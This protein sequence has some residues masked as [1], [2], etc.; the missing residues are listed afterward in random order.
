MTTTLAAP[1]EI[2]REFT[3]RSRSQLQ[4]AVRRFRRN[5]LAMGGLVTFLLM[6]LAAFAGPHFFSYRFDAQS[7]TL[8]AP[9]GTDGHLFGTDT[10]GRDVLLLTLRGIQWSMLMAAVFV[11]VACLLG[12]LVGAVSGYFGGLVDDVLMRAVDITLTLPFLAVVIVV[13]AAYPSARSPIGVAVLIALFSWMALARIVRA[14]FLSLRER[15]YVEAAQALGASDRRIVIRHL[16]PNSLGQIIVWATLGA[17]GAIGAEAALSFLGYGVQGSDI[18]LGRLVAEGAA[19]A[20]SRPWL[21]YF[22][23]LTLLL[24]VLAVSLV[25]D[26]IQDAFDPSAT[27]NR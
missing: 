20:A 13:A 26:G 14:S 16:I 24:I 10:I 22:P 3:V 7:T 25:G 23:G 17:T 15:E 27:R 12:I 11:V 4:L 8:S 19:A 21:F 5:G 9:P 1:A 18:S 6:L 2:E